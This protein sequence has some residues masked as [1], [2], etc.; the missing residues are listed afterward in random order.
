MIYWYKYHSVAYITTRDF[1]FFERP[2]FL[3]PEA[4]SWVQSNLR[5]MQPV[6][7]DT[8]MLSLKQQTEPCVQRQVGHTV[9]A[10]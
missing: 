9:R 4:S 5:W 1:N 10:W 3:L 6:G 8:D 7:M 2:P